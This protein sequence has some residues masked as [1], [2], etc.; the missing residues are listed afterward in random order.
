MA[1]I[2]TIKPEF[3][4]SE[5]MGKVSREARLCFILLWTLADDAGRMRGN[6]RMLASLLYPYDTDA[7]RLMD[8]WLGELSDNGCIQ[9]YEVAGN[10]YLQISAWLEHQKIDKP[11]ASRIPQ[12]PECD[13]G[14][15]ANVRESSPPDQ[16]KEGK[17]E[18]QGKDQGSSAEDEASPPLLSI[19]LVGDAE[20]GI[21]EP[22]VKEWSR[23]YPGV[24]VLQQ[25]RQMRVW[26]QAN[27][28]KRKTHRGLASFVV[29][30][31]TKAQDQ[32]GAIPNLRTANTSEPAWR[33]EQ[34]QRTQQAAPGVAVQDASDYF[35]DMEPTDVTPR[36]MGGSN[37][38]QAD[39]GLRP[40]LPAPLD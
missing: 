4:Q 10:S 37:L 21:T 19:P 15:F 31:L 32:S 3:P 27:P 18:D 33:T 23:A 14:T 28:T 36:S 35:L 1:R 7:G 11:S 29:R 40:V 12:P 13:A 38:R 24:D 26:A 9:R 20:F 5:S 17:G 16:G 8:K 39:A 6:P 25:L 34:R 2:R 22:M 30:W